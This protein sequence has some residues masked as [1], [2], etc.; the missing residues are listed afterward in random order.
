MGQAPRAGTL[1]ILGQPKGPGC[2]PAERRPR[3]HHGG[4]DAPR[5]RGPRPRPR[6]SRLP[7]P[8]QSGIHDAGGGALGGGGKG[9]ECASDNTYLQTHCHLWL[10]LH[11][12]AAH[13]AEARAGAVADTVAQFVGSFVACEDCGETKDGAQAR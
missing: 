13:A 10:L 4:R 1:R 6:R 5:R 12:L 9:D 7:S 2:P 8:A 11:C 3:T